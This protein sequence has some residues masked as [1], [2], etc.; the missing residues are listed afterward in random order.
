MF[1]ERNLED[2]PFVHFNPKTAQTPNLFSG[3]KPMREYND[4]Y[5]ELMRINE[6]TKESY[7]EFKSVVDQVRKQSHGIPYGV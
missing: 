2:F 1:H 6:L 3:S 5:S 4:L 7:K